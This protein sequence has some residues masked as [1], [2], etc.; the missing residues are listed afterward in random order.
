MLIWN[1]LQ[2]HTSP[3][4]KGNGKCLGNLQVFYVR[5]CNMNT[6]M[7]IER[8]VQCQMHVN[9]MAHCILFFMAKQIQYKCMFW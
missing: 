2:S 4:S 6:V 7:V 5:F 1:K 8:Y 3:V 9:V